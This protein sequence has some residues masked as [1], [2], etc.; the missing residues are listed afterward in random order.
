L[1]ENYGKI[2]RGVANG[3]RG[4]V[5]GFSCLNYL[6]EKEKMAGAVFG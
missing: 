1:S 6:G 4:Q 2:G 3:C 5:H